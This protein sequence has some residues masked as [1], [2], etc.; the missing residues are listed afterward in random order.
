[1]CFLLL[2]LFLLFSSLQFSH[3]GKTFVKNL[4][5]KGLQTAITCQR[6]SFISRNLNKLIYF[7]AREMTIA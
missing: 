2:K 7:K 3:T 5:P 1:M 4:N 6:G